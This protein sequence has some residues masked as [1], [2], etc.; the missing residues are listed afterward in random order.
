[1][2]RDLARHPRRLVAGVARR[3]RHERLDAPPHARGRPRTRGEDARPRRELPHAG[4]RPG[5]AGDRAG[6]HPHPPHARS[7]ALTGRPM[8][9]ETHL[10]LHGVRAAELRTEAGSC[11]PAGVPRRPGPL[12]TRVGWT[13]VEVGLRLAAVRGTAAVAAAS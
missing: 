11:R 4:L 5:Y 9:P 2:A 13:L 8:H 12:R 7:E 1:G 6:A 3:L 10:I